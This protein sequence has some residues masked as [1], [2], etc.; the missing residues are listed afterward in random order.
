MCQYIEFVADRLIES[1]GY[2]KI[3]HAR[4]PFEWMELISL[5]GKASKSSL[6]QNEVKSWA[7]MQDFFESRVS[8]YQKAGVSRVDSIEAKAGDN[9]GSQR[10]VF[11]TDAD[12]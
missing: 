5:Q 1:L 7:E 3:Y 6:Y 8:S 2:T 4:N 10:R 11:R 12:F 9:G